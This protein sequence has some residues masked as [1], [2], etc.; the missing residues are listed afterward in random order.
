VP[1]CGRGNLRDLRRD[2][3]RKG[4]GGCADSGKAAG[5]GSRYDRPKNL[6]E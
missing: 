6:R 3:I 5:L 4:G 1:V 2:H